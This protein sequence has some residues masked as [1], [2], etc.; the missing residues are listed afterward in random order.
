MVGDHVGRGHHRAAPDVVDTFQ[1]DHRA[2]ARL[3]QD[4]AVEALEC[5]LTRAVELDL[6]IRVQRPCR[7]VAARPG[8]A[9][10]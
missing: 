2:Q 8:I 7:E 3:G 9:R 5:T 10:R 1:Q 6:L 4:I